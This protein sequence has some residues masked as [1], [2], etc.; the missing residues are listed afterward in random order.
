[1]IVVQPRGGLCNCLRVVFSYTELA[2]AKGDKLIVIWIWSSACPGFFLD[3]FQAV[4]NVTF[5]RDNKKGYPINYHGWGC[6]PGYAPNYSSLRLLPAVQKM[7]DD[8]VS[9]LKQPFIAIHVRRTD[10]VADAKARNMFTNDEAFFRFVDSQPKEQSLYV[11]CD[12][13]ATYTVFAKRYGGRIKFPFWPSNQK[14]LRQTSLR[15]AVIDLFV[16]TRAT[17][18]MGSGWSSFSTAIGDMR[19][20]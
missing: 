7:V 8:R 14:Q 6:A 4:P 17:T 11:A 13:A 12:N 3:Y 9:A 1:M 19:K 15:D 20:K 16:C 5:E 10:H 2:K 18:F